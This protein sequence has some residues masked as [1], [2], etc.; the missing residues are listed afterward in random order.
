MRRNVRQV[1]SHKV[2]EAHIQHS[3]TPWTQEHAELN[4]RA[5]TFSGGKNFWLH[6]MTGKN[7]NMSPFSENCD[8]IEDVQIFTFLTD[9]TDENTKTWIIILN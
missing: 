7:C 9:Y 4:T 8:S 6:N 1:K 2:R 5:D 3:R